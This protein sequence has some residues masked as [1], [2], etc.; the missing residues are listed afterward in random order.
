MTV[1][2]GVV[3]VV[4]LAMNGALFYVLR[5][6]AFATKKQVKRCFVKEMEAYSGFLAEKREESR[7]IGEE[8]DALQEEVR[9]LEGVVL[10]LKTSPFYAPRPVARELFIP[11]ARYID[12]EFF[13]NHKR[14]TDMLRDMDY[15]EI[16][17]KIADTHAYEGNLQDYQAACNLLS[18]LSMDMTYE[19]CTVEPGTQLIVL[20]AALAGM[21]GM[22][23]DL[24]ER[25]LE[26]LGNEEEDFDVLD[27]RTFVREIRVAQDP[28]MYVR[29]G[30]ETLE[31][32]EDWEGLEHQYDANISEGLKVIYQNR[33]YDFSIYR[34]RSR[35]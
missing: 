9:E 34:L 29:T 17:D 4:M 10:S 27:F 1:I 31:E 5:Q 33:S 28:T 32:I 8:R 30:R 14:V 13:D 26:T 24:L 7:Q 25:Y 22:G 19:L 20:R 11:T 21:G 3:M 16:V 23:G 35:K 6:A 12:N 18:F 15:Q 2:L